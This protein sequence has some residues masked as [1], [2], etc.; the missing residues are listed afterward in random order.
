VED[1]FFWWVVVSNEFVCIFELLN[2]IKMNNELTPHIEYHDNGNVLVKGKL[3]SV[4]KRDG[5]WEGFYENGN[6]HWRTPFKES[7]RDGVREC[8]DEQGNIKWRIP[9]KG[10][11]KDG[12]EEW[13]HPNGN[14]IKTYVWKDGELIEETEP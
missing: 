1:N 3:N 11:K 6:I 2:P 13:F 9:Y 14:I 10:G 5:I 8:F 4:G 7:K 12:I